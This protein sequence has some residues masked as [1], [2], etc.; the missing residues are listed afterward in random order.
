MHTHRRRRR[1]S[2]RRLLVGRSSLRSPRSQRVLRVASRCTRTAAAAAAAGGCLLDV[3]ACGRGAQSARAESSIKDAHVPQ[4][5]PQQQSPAV[6]AQSVRAK[7]SIKDAHVPQPWTQQPA[8]AASSQRVLRVVSKMHTHRRP[9][10]SRGK[11]LALRTS[12][13]STHNN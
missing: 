5:P 10:R 12:E 6:T 1:R 11:N 3:V 7:S 8:V 9:R 2:R 13:V 4:P